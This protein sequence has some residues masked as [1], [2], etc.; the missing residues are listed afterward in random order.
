[1][2]HAHPSRQVAA[3][4]GAVDGRGRNPG[5]VENGGD[6][7]DHLLDGQRLLRQVGAGV[8]M[9]RHADTAVFDHD[10]VQARLRGTT[11]QSLVVA[12]RGHPG[13]AGD[14]YQRLMLRGPVRT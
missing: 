5:V 6:V 7:V 9:S 11:A 2:P 4:G 1:M 14:D 13:S 8:V 12:D 10:D 3:V